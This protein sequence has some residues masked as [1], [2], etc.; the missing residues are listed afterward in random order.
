MSS[1][2]VN[3]AGAGKCFVCFLCDFAFYSFAAR[4]SPLFFF[5]DFGWPFV[6][7]TADKSHRCPLLICR[8]LVLIYVDG[9]FDSGLSLVVVRGS[10]QHE[11]GSRAKVATQIACDI[12]LFIF[13]DNGVCIGFGI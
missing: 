4:F 1:S 7:A 10:V 5:I 6:A 13:I 2:S 12:C 3:V 9:L 8:T 11:L